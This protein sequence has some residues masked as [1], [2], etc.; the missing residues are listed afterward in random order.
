MDV[1][2]GIRGK[3]K[4]VSSILLVVVLMEGMRSV[5]RRIILKVTIRDINV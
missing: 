2:C 5:D 3:D 4:K 1:T